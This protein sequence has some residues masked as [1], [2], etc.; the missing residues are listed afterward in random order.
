MHNCHDLRT[1]K[2]W[3]TSSGES[4]RLGHARTSITMDIYVHGNDEQQHEAANTFAASIFDEKFIV[5]KD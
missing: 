3:N 1:L 4:D 5:N 2:L